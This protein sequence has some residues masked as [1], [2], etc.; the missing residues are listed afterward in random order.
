VT[1]S[2]LVNRVIPALNVEPRK[3]GLTVTILLLHYT[4]MSDADKACQWLCSEESGVSCH[5][6]VDEDGA[7]T[8]MVDEELRAWHSG[9][10]SWHGQIDINSCSIG[11]EI[12]N[13]GH[14]DGYPAF[15]DAQMQAVATLSKDIMTRHKID[16]RLV[17]AHSDVAP[18]RKADPG[19]KFDWPLLHSA[20][21]GHWVSPEAIS[22]GPM[23]Q[24]GD[25]G[26]PVAALQAM[27]KIYGY[28]IDVSGIYDQRTKVVVE[29]FQR[30]FRPALCDG[31][32]DYSTVATLRKLLEP[33]E[34]S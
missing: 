5:Y 8:Q 7:I 30:H 12:Q 22:G 13:R 21:V 20:G 4:G 3:N 25:Q 9:V 6:L 14:N 10:S 19:E 34:S 27:L 26:D 24:A 32:A 16:P 23:M 17:L 31:I 18:G 29:A 11:I 1:G 28:G 2:N 15:P 33:V